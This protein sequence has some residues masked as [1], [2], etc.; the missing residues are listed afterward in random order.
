MLAE[1]LDSDVQVDQKLKNMLYD[2][3]YLGVQPYSIGPMKRT[4]FLQFPPSYDLSE[5]K[6]FN[7]QLSPSSESDRNPT[8]S[9]S[10][11]T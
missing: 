5:F 6:C 11:V 1:A 7:A 2:A 10:M 9:Q 4:E 8:L 3:L